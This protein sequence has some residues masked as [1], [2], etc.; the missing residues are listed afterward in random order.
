MLLCLYFYGI[1]LLWEF[2]YVDFWN[3]KRGTVVD[4]KNLPPLG[5][6]SQKCWSLGVKCPV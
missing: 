1:Y 2:M 3:P 5:M 6:F 4:L